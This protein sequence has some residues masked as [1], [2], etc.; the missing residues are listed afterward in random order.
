[1]ASFEEEERA[2]EIRDKEDAAIIAA[3]VES[4]K[5][6]TSS[7]RGGSVLGHGTVERFREDGRERLFRDYFADSPVYGPRFFR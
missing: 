2:A 5:G 3:L 1:M 7:G 4:Q 6:G